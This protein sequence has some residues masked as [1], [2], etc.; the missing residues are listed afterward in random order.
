V[1]DDRLLG[2]LPDIPL[3]PGSLRFSPDG[4]LLVGRFEN[5][6]PGQPAD[7]RVVDWQ[8]NKVVFQPPFPVYACDFL[9]DG[10]RLYLAQV[11]GT[12]SIY[13]TADWKEVARLKTG[14]VNRTYP[15]V[16]HPD[17]TRVAVPDGKTIGIWEV[18][19]GKLLYQVADGGG[20]LAWHPRGDLL[21]V[22]Y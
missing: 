2:L 17:G 13:E 3:T 14:P 9:P 22:G 20:S 12:I 6:I 8:R 18:A 7:F 10:R 19:S 15:P 1:A 5:P 16:F 4:S 11:D 21:A